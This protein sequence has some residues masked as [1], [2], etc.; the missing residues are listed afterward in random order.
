MSE[1]KHELWTGPDRTSLRTFV[2]Q[3]DVVLGCDIVRQVMVENQPKETIQKC[4]IDLLVYF[5]KDGLHE[6]VA[7]ALAGLP[8]VRQVVDTLAPLVNEERRR[9][10]VRRL[11]PSR[12]KTTFVSP[13]VKVSVDRMPR[14]WA[15]NLLEEQELIQVLRIEDQ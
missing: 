8:D 15:Q 12:E 1:K 10:S 2:G 7:L 11:D 13:I 6:D 3:D 4:E 9:F 14:N 5:G